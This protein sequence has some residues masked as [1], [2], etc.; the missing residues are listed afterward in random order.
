MNLDLVITALKNRA[1]FFA[2]NVAGAAAYARGVSDQVWLPTPAAYVVPLE[3]EASPNDDMGGSNYQRLTERINV[4]VQF[5][6]SADRR[7][8]TVTELYEP[9]K[10]QLLGAILNWRPNSSIDNP[11]IV[12]AGQP[13]IDCS[14]QGISLVGHGLLDLDLS[15]LFYRWTF[16]LISMISDADGW[17]P[18]SVPLT[19]VSVN[20]PN[21]DGTP[22]G[23]PFGVT[24]PQ[25]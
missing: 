6:N 9:V 19:G 13:G 22:N 2:G 1:P 4:I 5:D 23:I 3:G 25:S 20:D 17:Q 16:E 21:P 8:Q 18:P 14:S 24:L 10:Y 11:G 12:V 7:G 15:R